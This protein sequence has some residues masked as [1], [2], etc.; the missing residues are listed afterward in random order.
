MSDS[1]SSAFAWCS[2]A[3]MQAHLAGT[4]HP[5]S[6]RRLEVLDALA[7]SLRPDRLDVCPAGGDR[8]LLCHSEMYLDTARA[9]IH[10]GREMLSTGDTQITANSWQAALS[11]AGC[12]VCAVDTVCR[13]LRRRVFC[14]VRPPGHH[15]SRSRGMGFC[16]LN[17]AA[18]AACHARETFGLERVLIADW[19]VHHGNGT[20]DIF[21]EDPGVFFF[22]THQ[23]PWYPGTGQREETGAGPG[24]GTTMNRPFPAG[25]GRDEIFGAFDNDLREAMKPTGRSW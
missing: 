19:D 18:I 7:D 14:A 16:I 17:H 6:P 4:G 11:A 24:H 9:D 15:A 22:S 13:G 23:T 25:A 5:E 12:A 20:Q 2:D 3:V 1:G 8:L 10:Q 21:Y